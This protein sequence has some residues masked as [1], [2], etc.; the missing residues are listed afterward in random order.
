MSDDET[1]RL[2]AT[3]THLRTWINGML[4]RPGMYVPGPGG[5]QTGMTLLGDTLAIAEG[6]PDA[7]AVELDGLKER[8]AWTP[9][10]V[11][12]AY[13]N[14]LGVQGPAPTALMFAACAYRL[15][16]FDVERPLSPHEY[17]AVR[18]AVP[19]LTESDA[20]GSSIIERFGPPSVQTS[21][22][23]WIHDSL[24]YLSRSASDPA[25]FFHFEP[26]PLG[27]N[28]SADRFRLLAAHIDQG[29]FF[30]GFTHTPHGRAVREAS[31]EDRQNQAR[32]VVRKRTRQRERSKGSS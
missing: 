24:L 17:A 5:V 10:G 22:G 12:G 25:I 23:R 30:D 29:A 18:A 6:R 28:R 31:N 14:V 20:T 7:W 13:H 21:P 11:T 15:G 27:T 2:D 9:I 19:G 26:P 16:W 1:D 8:G 4:R 32:A 3:I